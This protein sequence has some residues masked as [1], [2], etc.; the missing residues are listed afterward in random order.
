MKEFINTVQK[1]LDLT[2][3][4]S[5]I[6]ALKEYENELLDW[7][8]RFNLTAIRDT[9][10]IRIKHFLDSFTCLMVIRDPVG[11][12]IDVGTGAGF[13]G[14][15]LKIV[16]PTLHLTLVESVGKKIKFC[17]HIVKHLGLEDVDVIQERAEALGQ[18]PKHRQ[19]YDWALARAVAIMPV[20]IEY[21]LPLVKVGG[22]MIAMK[23]ETAHPE[24]HSADYAIQLLGG[25]L[26]KIIPI[27]LPSVVEN[28]H[29][30]VIDKVAATP[31]TYPRRTGLPAKHPLQTQNQSQN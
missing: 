22:S 31:D 12:V 5:Q 21:L 6:S 30:V 24:T 4:P 1:M 17:K 3:S 10:Q 19:K 13:P 11:K 15:P 8:S 14:I 9:E 28:R 26:R 20:L 25:H 7:N 29:L 18:I 2:L 16:S 27:T 23:G